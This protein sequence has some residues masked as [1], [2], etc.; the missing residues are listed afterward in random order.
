MKLL[1]VIGTRPNFIKVAPLVEEF[2]KYRKIKSILVH[3]GQ[4][5][6]YEMSQVFFR[7]FNIPK[8]NYNLGV[9]S[10]S[11]ACQMAKVIEK[12][13]R[14]VLKEKPDKIMVFG[15]VNSTLAGALVAAKLDIPVAHVEAGL[16]SY[17]KAMPEEINRL[18]TDHVSE[19]LFCPTENAV[20]N[21]RKE[22]IK[23]GLAYNVGDIMYDALLGARNKIKKSKILKKLN[24]TPKS[25]ILMTVHRASNTDNLENLKKIIIAVGKSREKI[26]FPIHPRTRKQLKKIKLSKFENLEIIK[27]V[28]YLDMLA[29]EKDAK[30]ILTDSGGIQ[31]EA[32]WLKVPCIT[33]R[34]ETEWI[35]TVKDGWNIL[36]GVNEAK[37]LK[38][39]K[40]FNPNKKQK[41]YFGKGDTAKKI[42]KIILQK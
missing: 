14:V 5:Y 24:L 38:A 30:K 11:H 3:T 29:L 10:F 7:D 26:I 40:T 13:E 15:D 21:L 33:L 37:I 35:E 32:Y 2:K 42:I 27:P 1:L 28:S 39:I 36:T 8:P 31:K 6:D 22:G 16:R 23:K 25:Y 34:K 19:L 20:K 9:G 18:L 17:D 12:L 41:N 4:H